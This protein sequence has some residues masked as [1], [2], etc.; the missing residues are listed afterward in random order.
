[1]P[2]NKGKLRAKARNFQFD[3]VTNSGLRRNIV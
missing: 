3:G 1:M 2:E